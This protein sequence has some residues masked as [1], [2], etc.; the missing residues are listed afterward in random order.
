MDWVGCFT[1]MDAIGDTRFNAC[2][3]YYFT[4]MDEGCYNGS[5][6]EENDTII[7][8]DSM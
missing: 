5:K 2:S 7:T 4:I 1:A 8:D 3:N 6:E